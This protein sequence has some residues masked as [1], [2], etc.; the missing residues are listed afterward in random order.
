[1]KFSWSYSA[2]KDFENCPRKYHEIRVL[3]NYQVKK[4]EQILY[5]ESL[6]KAAEEYVKDGTPIP[7]QFAFMQP[8]IDALLSKNGEKHAE[9]QMALNHELQPCG[10]FDKDVWVRGLADLLIIDHDENMA[11]VVD[12]KTGSNKYPDKSQLE[13]MA[14][15]VMTYFPN[16]VQVNGGLLFV[17][18]GG[19]VKHKIRREEYD[20]LWW[21]Y[22]ERVAN[23]AAAKENNVWNPKQ[24]GLCGWCE[25]NSC[26]FNPKHD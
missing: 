4:S 15:M 14:L 22:K 7:K 19:L 18:K 25:V 2:L 6:H 24:S 11:W 26:E 13:L 12:Y 5:G 9:F 16:V 3:K 8:I 17:V 20:E 21:K 23:I 10:F 1:M